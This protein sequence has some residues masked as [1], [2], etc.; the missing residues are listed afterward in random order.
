MILG[1]EGVYQFSRLPNFPEY[2]FNT[3]PTQHTCTSNSNPCCIFFDTCTNVG[4]QLESHSFKE[5]IHH[6]FFILPF[7]SIAI[8]LY[9][10]NFTFSLFIYF[11]GRGGGLLEILLIPCPSY[12]SCVTMP[13]YNNLILIS[14]CIITTIILIQLG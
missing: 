10:W 4:L 1:Q 2:G 13:L 7:L 8:Q 6:L 9:Y 12:F 14:K 3:P 11:E 5:Q